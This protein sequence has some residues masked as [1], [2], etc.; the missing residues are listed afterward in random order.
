[1]IRL[2]ACA[3]AL[4]AMF[5]ATG[6][7]AQDTFQV[8][9]TTLTAT[10]VASG[11][12]LPW[13][14]LWGPD[15]F[16]WVTSRPGTVYR[17]NPETGATTTVLTKSVTNNGSGEPGMLGMAMHPEWETTP[18]VFIVYT[19]GS[20][21]NGT[22][23]LSVFDWNGSSLVNEEVLLSLPAAGIHNGSR[24]LVLPDNTLLMTTGDVGDG[25]ASSQNLS[26]LN[27]KVLRLNLDG[28][29]PSDNPTPGSYV[30]SHGHRN[31]QG[32]AMGPGGIIYSSEHGQS[33]N[34][35]VNIIEPGRNYGWPNVEGGM[36]VTGETQWFA[37]YGQRIRDVAVNPYT[38]AVYLAFNGP[39]YPGSGPNIIKEFRNMDYVP[40]TSVAGCR[41]PGALNYNANATEDDNSCQFAGCTDPT[42]L[43][44]VPWANVT[45]T[46][47]YTAPCPEDVNG[48]G[49]T[50]VSDMLLV[51]GAFGDV[52]N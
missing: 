45:T 6:L 22:E 16:L 51:L 15:D 52:C 28:S 11:I 14:I 32:L 7:R 48:D 42:A 33:N 34:D 39:S 43:N 41:Y 13:E 47:M 46:C 8:G 26:S 17:I 44:Y 3:G 19:T 24:L 50:T 36:S 2:L 35:E 23:R 27:G 9:N 40:V 30:Y 21:W 31:P 38:G 25:G 49:A 4:L 5:A 12:Q 10:N 18:K 37:S 20:T 29:I 1:M